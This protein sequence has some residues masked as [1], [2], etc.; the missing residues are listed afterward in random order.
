MQNSCLYHT[1]MGTAHTIR[2][3]FDMCMMHEARM[4][5]HKGLPAV[6]TVPAVHCA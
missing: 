4:F 5:V 1:T 6:L 2:Y 3:D